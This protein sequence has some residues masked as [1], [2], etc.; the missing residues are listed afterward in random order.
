M[1]VS[2]TLQGPGKEAA[3]VIAQTFTVRP[4]DTAGAAKERLALLEPAAALPGARL[5]YAG[6]ELDDETRFADSGVKEGASLD[7]V[8]GTSAEDF[9]Q[10]L[11]E[12]LQ[13]RDLPLEELGLLY[14]HRHGATAGQVLKLLGRDETLSQFLQGSKQFVVEA[15]RARAAA[16]EREPAGASLLRIPEE[17]D[18]P[19]RAEGAKV[20]VVVR[21][22]TPCAG[23]VLTDVVLDV[24]AADTV[25]TLKEKVSEIEM[26]PF[27]DKDVLLD[28]AVLED[29][30]RLL[31]CGISSESRVELLARATEQGLAGQ[32]AKLLE[33]RGQRV[34]SPDDLSLLFCYTYGAPVARA[35]KL[36]G[37]KESFRSFLKRQGKPA[38]CGRG[39]AQAGGAVQGLPPSL[40]LRSSSP[41]P[42]SR[43]RP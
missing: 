28:G 43:R 23:E 9:A 40:L 6:K 20:S 4:E 12:L 38:S 15:G 29:G 10:Q 8:A 36:L 1:K 35:L 39:A 22:Q 19:P 26:I 30:L 2:V 14:S 37:L 34:L 7:L 33:G 17:E 16:A 41:P 27:S 5:L 11:E 21:M 31:D 3:A 25:R 32:L 24:G 13:A 42:P 18:E